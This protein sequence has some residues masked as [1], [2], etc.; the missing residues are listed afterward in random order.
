MSGL[1]PCV[2]VDPRPFA[3]TQCGCMVVC[4]RWLERPPYPLGPVPPTEGVLRHCAAVRP[5]I[6]HRPSLWR[7]CASAYAAPD[8]DF[9]ASFPL[10]TMSC[11]ALST[12]HCLHIN[13]DSGRLTTHQ[14]YHI[15][16]KLSRYGAPRGNRTHVNSLQNYCSATKLWG[17]IK[18]YFLPLFSLS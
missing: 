18:L 6:S 11:M 17:Q 10:V 2:R 5:S 13:I 3:A 9:L 1:Y 14:S 12:R 7:K 4:K 15:A 16:N 8:D